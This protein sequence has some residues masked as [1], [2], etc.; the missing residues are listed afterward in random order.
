MLS[1]LVSCAGTGECLGYKLPL[2]GRWYTPTQSRQ[3]G[4]GCLGFIT[5]CRSTG[6]KDLTLIFLELGVYTSIFFISD[7]VFFFLIIF[8][9]RPNSTPIHTH[10]LRNLLVVLLVSSF[11]QWSLRRRDGR[12]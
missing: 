4:Q 5:V 7:K 10:L 12:R 9:V 1:L 3:A 11:V 8:V 2:K 6:S